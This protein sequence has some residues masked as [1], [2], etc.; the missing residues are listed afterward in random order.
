M[1][2][3]P[4]V[5]LAL[6]IIYWH[7]G[8]LRRTLREPHPA[9]PLVP[10]RPAAPPCVSVIVP[11]RNEAHRIGPCLAGLAAQRY[12]SFEIIVI[13]DGSTDGTAEVV[14]AAAATFPALQL[15]AAAPLPAG[16]VGK[17]WA[18]WQG[19]QV[20]RGEWLLFLDADVAP[21]P[22]LIATL[23]ESADPSSAMISLV[24]LIQAVS[25]AERIVLPPF[26]AL[27][28]AI[29]RF[30]QVNDPGS[31]EAFAIGQCLFVR[32]SAY[33]AIQGHAAIRASVLED[34]E[35]ATRLK[36][37]EYRIRVFFAPR[38]LRV[39]MYTDW[40]ALNEGLQ[41][42]AIAGLLHGGA[43]ARRTALRFMLMALLPWYS[44]VAGVVAI[45]SGAD[46]AIGQVLLVLALLLMLI[47][48]ICQGIIARVRHRISIAWGVFF[49]LGLAI[50]FGLTLA[51]YLRVRR[52]RGV[53][54]KGRVLTGK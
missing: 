45:Q 4:V 7:L 2:L 25:V 3:L 19:A 50:Y 28:S 51:A 48:S 53:R 17:N 24:P 32:Q 8:D 52:G 10:P 39:R 46:A 9:V 20:A 22:E 31:H 42:N 13:D 1:V 5:V 47:G 12:Q 30:A 38:L 26:T 11:A 29:Y 40:S 23:V 41:K 35:L 16:W 21:E 54:W 49:P 43:R 27:I 15:L 44:A 37:A 6:L 34:M 36:H 18:C 33:H 14:R